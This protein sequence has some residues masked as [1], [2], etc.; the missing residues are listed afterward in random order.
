M[1]E[2]SKKRLLEDLSE[3]EHVQ[4]M[5]WSMV[6]AKTETLEP[7]RLVKWKECWKEYSELTEAQKEQDRIYARRVLQIVG[8]Y[9]G[10]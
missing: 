1:D 4:W 9:L 8:R 7:S 3:L 2:D 6:L 10:E 5:E